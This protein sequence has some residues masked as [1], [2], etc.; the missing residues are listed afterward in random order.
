MGE[1]GG[2]LNQKLAGGVTEFTPTPT[3]SKEIIRQ[4]YKI[5]KTLMVLTPVLHEEHA[6]SPLRMRLHSVRFADDSID[7]TLEMADALRNC[8]SQVEISV[9]EVVGFGHVTPLG[10]DISWDVGGL[11]T[12]VDAL[13]QAIKAEVLQKP[14]MLAQKIVDWLTV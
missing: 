12:P 5:P 6:Q 4:G 14:K 11:F 13:N 9:E 3:E 10:A 1:M 7:E 2:V 8:P